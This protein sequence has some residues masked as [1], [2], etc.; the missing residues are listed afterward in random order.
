MQK[1]GQHGETTCLGSNSALHAPGGLCV[2]G[3]GPATM[4]GGCPDVPGVLWKAA[5][6]GFSL[7]G[8]S[9]V[10]QRSQADI[11]CH[12]GHV[13]SGACASPG[14]DSQDEAETS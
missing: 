6:V 10:L 13:L 1:L 2:Q 7:C 14:S 11:R 3:H 5:H 8:L 12:K 9:I 4:L